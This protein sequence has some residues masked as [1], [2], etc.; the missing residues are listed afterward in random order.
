MLLNCAD[1]HYCI[2]SGALYVIILLNSLTFL[3][4]EHLTFET[5]YL[6]IRSLT[7]IC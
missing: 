2:L 7:L 1:L 4:V 6:E 3:Q 5:W